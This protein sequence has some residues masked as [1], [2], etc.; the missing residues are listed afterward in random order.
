[1]EPT[2]RDSYESRLM[3]VVSLIVN[4]GIIRATT[5][6]ATPNLYAMFMEA[7]ADWCREVGCLQHTILDIGRRIGVEH[8][9]MVNQ[10]I[11][12][13]FRPGKRVVNSY[14]SLNALLKVANEKDPRD[15]LKYLMQAGENYARDLQ[16]RYNVRRKR[17]VEL[18]GYDAE[19]FYST[20]DPGAFADRDGRSP[21]EKMIAHECANSFLR[22]L[23]QRNFTSDLVILAQASGLLRTEIADYFAEERLPALVAYVTRELSFVAERDCSPFMVTLMEKARTFVLPPRLKEDRK[24][25]INYLFRQTNGAAREKLNRR[26]EAHGL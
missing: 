10:F 8:D 16:R 9:Q 12:Y 23:G 14:P 26:K 24:A 18:R 2:T 1:M 21:E 22:E 25:L 19:G 6:L 3:Y 17:Q 13:L 11:T 5:L 4:A 7:L 15:V 20:I